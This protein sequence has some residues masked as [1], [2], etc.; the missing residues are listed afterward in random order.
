MLAAA[1]KVLLK[2][3]ENNEIKKK[4]ILFRGKMLKK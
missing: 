4:K 3:D 1:G 2:D